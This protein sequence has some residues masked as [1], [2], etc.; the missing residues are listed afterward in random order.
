MVKTFQ[1]LGLYTDKSRD[2]GKLTK[3]SL[4]GK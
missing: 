3:I 1:Y 2:H 4:Q